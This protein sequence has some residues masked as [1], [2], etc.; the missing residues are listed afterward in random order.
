[1]RSHPFICLRNTNMAIKRKTSHSHHH[2]RICLQ[3]I[4]LT[5]KRWFLQG[6]GG[7]TPSNLKAHLQGEKSE[8]YGWGTPNREE[9]CKE[10]SYGLH[11]YNVNH[12]HHKVNRASLGIRWTSLPWAKSIYVE[13]TKSSKWETNLI[14][15]SKD[16][17]FLVRTTC[18]EYGAIWLTFSFHLEIWLYVPLFRLCSFL[19]ALAALYLPF[20]CPF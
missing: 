5:N 7:R 15:Y 10:I 14:I 6:K 13:L 18:S 17:K 2:P 1:M 19:A 12:I 9:I 20:L 3:L 4:Q 8:K 16:N 11:L